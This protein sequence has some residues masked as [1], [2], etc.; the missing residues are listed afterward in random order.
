[1]FCLRWTIG[2]CFLCC[3]CPCIALVSLLGPAEL[4]DIPEDYEPMPW[5]YYKVSGVY[6]CVGAHGGGDSSVVRAM[7]W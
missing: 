5:E 7:D 4:A 1:M 6:V 3:H 2:V